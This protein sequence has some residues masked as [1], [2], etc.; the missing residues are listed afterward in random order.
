V[1]N[2][3]EPVRLE[4]RHESEIVDQV[5]GG[6]V[7][8]VRSPGDGDPEPAWWDATAPDGQRGWIRSWALRPVEPE[9]PWLAE[10]GLHVRRRWIRAEGT[11]G[12]EVALG[13][14]V[15][16]LA[17]ARGDRGTQGMQGTQGTQEARGDRVA[18]LTPSGETLTVARDDLDD[19][20]TAMRAGFYGPPSRSAPPAPDLATLLSRAIGPG[21]ALAEH[22]LD[23]PYLWGGVGPGGI[24]CSGLVLLCLGLEGLLLPRNSGDQ[25]G[26]FREAGLALGPVA[27]FAENDRTEGLLFFGDGPD[28]TD[29]VGLLGRGGVMIHASGRVR[30]TVLDPARDG[31]AVRYLRRLRWV[32]RA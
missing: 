12:R 24:D 6:M 4:P 29:H 25:C 1:T 17:P 13:V 26:I 18:L 8:E 14:G 27:G 7:V 23:T 22:L 19:A 28:A 2:Q 5:I 20:G 10:A 31:E 30:T 11:G 21:R 3:V 16:G 9:S 15:R 32:V